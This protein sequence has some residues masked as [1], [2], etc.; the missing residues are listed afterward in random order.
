MVWTRFPLLA[1]SGI[2]HPKDMLKPKCLLSGS[3]VR[4]GRDCRMSAQGRLQSLS[5]IEYKHLV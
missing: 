2:A 3:D 1:E 5:E 4:I